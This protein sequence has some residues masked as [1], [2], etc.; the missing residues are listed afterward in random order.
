LEELLPVVVKTTLSSF[1]CF[2]HIN[3]VVLMHISPHLHVSMPNVEK[4]T[5][6]SV[7]TP[8]IYL[9]TSLGT[10]HGGTALSAV[11]ELDIRRCHGLADDAALGH[12]HD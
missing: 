11:L 7:L 4:L 9:L 2:L 10:I 8:P 1:E 5:D 3:K 6:V 12:G